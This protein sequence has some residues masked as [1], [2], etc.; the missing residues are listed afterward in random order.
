MEYCLSCNDEKAGCTLITKDPYV[1]PRLKITKKTIL[2][3]ARMLIHV[4]NT[5]FNQRI[6]H[7]ALTFNCFILGAA[8]LRSLLS[9]LA[10]ILRCLSGS[11]IS[12]MR[13]F[14]SRRFL[15]RSS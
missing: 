2:E 8:F 9:S 5:Y 12:L 7:I 13:S 10:S 1:I 11:S 15:S 6:N 14:N 3:P 4:P